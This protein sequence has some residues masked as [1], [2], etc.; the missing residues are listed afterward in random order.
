LGFGLVERLDVEVTGEVGV[1][2]VRV[3]ADG[4]GCDL[5]YDLAVEMPEPCAAC[6]YYP[7]H[8]SDLHELI[9]SPALSW[10]TVVLRPTYAKLGAFFVIQ[11]LVP[12]W[13]VGAEEGFLLE[14]LVCEDPQEL[15]KMLRPTC[16][17]HV[18]ADGLHGIA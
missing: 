17:F 12:A 15:Q 2:V 5:T 14:R 1:V 9:L 4:M 7:G 13:S 8:W 10:A 6:Y 3:S 18:F 11:L 16:H